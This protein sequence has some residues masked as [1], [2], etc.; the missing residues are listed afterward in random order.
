M[1]RPAVFRRPL[2]A[3]AF[4]VLLLGAMPAASLAAQSLTGG[5]LQGDVVTADGTPVPGMTLTLEDYS[6]LELRQLQTDPR[7]HFSIALLEP[8]RYSLLAERVGFQPLRQRGIDVLA[9]VRTTVTIRVERRPP[10][11]TSV[12]EVAVATQQFTPNAPRIAERLGDGP[13]AWWAPVA[14]ITVDGRASALV[15]APFDTRRGLALAI[16][17]LPQS[18]SRLLIDGLPGSWLRHPGLPHEPGTTPL[19]ARQLTQQAVLATTTSDGE[20][21]GGNGAM[22]GVVSRPP[23]ARRRAEPFAFWSGGLGTPGRDNP[24]DSSATSYAVGFTVSGP[25]VPGRANVIVGLALE[26]EQLPGADP[27]T[28]D[29]ARLNGGSV[30]LASALE[31][32]ATAQGISLRGATRPVVRD[33]RGGSGGFRVDWRLSPSWVVITRASLARYRERA[34]LLAPDLSNGAGSRLEAK[35]YGITTSFSYAEGDWGNELRVGFRGTT[36]DWSASRLPSTVF[37]AEG[38]GIGGLP[39]TAGDFTYRGVDLSEAFQYSFGRRRQHRVKAGFQYSSGFWTQDHLAGAQGVY[40][41]GNLDGFEDLRGAFWVAEA[42]STRARFKLVE[43]GLFMHIGWELRPALTGIAGI[44]YDRQKVPGTRGANITV[45]PQ[46]RTDFGLPNFV[47]PSDTRGFTPRLGLQWT[48]PAGGWSGSLFATQAVGQ[49]NPAYFAEAMLM[50]GG[51]TVRRAVGALGTWATLPD[52]T[53]A[54]TVGRRYTLFSPDST[55]HQ[56]RTTKLDAE[57]TRSL[58]TTGTL[59]VLGS[60]HHTDYLLRRADLNLLSAPTGLTQEGRP[61]YGTLQQEGGLLAAVPGSNRRVAGYDVVSALAPDGFQDYYQ[62]GAVLEA[63]LGGGLAVSASYLWSRTR[64]NWLTATT[65]TAEDEL[66]PFAGQKSGKSEWA[67]GISDFDVPHRAVV[68]A[69]WR[70][71]G[72]LPLRVGARYRIRSGLPFTPGFR[73]GV[74]ANADGSGRNDPAYLDPAIPGLPALLARNPCLNEQSGQMAARNSCREP[75]NRALDL[76]FA[77]GLPLRSL[78]G[79]LELLVDVFN[80]ATTDVGLVDR[81]LVLVDPAGALTTD[82]LGNVTLPLVANPHFGKLQ[83]RRIDPRVIRFGLRLVP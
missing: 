10:P 16:G 75:A 25:L 18:Q 54:P 27:W 12:V 62:A 67:Y 64:D 44:R 33:T 24:G 22:L 35:D 80:L 13:E 15:A 31:T 38:I 21:S 65:G 47:V 39:S 73:P 32:V 66:S 50:D 69:T 78:G 46:F 48:R 41:F 36:R 5:A 82:A 2:C 57:L 45:D 74:D 14:G 56:P 11:I 71:P 40:T 20:W 4:G 60:Y 52:S 3:C 43:A 34:P 30:N 70:A 42:A 51:V 1:A 8:G 6:G 81:A 26:R 68:E 79:Q 59:R 29:S 58:G 63:S 76:S 19:L 37:A 28:V 17:G 49:L 7:G 61:V 9:E 77:V 83:S 55:Y 53:V 23:T 72:R